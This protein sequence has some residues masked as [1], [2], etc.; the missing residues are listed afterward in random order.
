MMEKETK[1]VNRSWSAAEHWVQRAVTGDW[2]AMPGLGLLREAHRGCH[3]HTAYPPGRWTDSDQPWAGVWKHAV[4]PR[5]EIEMKPN[6]KTKLFHVSYVDMKFRTTPSTCRRLLDKVV[7][8][9]SYSQLWIPRFRA[10]DKVTRKLPYREGHLGEHPHEIATLKKIIHPK[11][12]SWGCNFQTR[13]ERNE[14]TL[15]L[16]NCIKEQKDM[17]PKHESPGSE[18]VQYATAE[19][20]RKTTKAPERMKQLGQS[21][22]DTQLWMCLVMKVKPDAAKNSIAQEHG[23][24]G[25]SVKVNWTWSSRRWQE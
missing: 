18:G 20:W 10:R 7:H 5:P 11:N 12:R 23:M 13:R 17:T 25:P 1:V 8:I 2:A 4:Y 21:G 16:L 6:N 14:Q 15:N 22:K 24:L 9:I 19:E 3:E